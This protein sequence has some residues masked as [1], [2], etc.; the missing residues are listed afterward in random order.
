VVVESQAVRVELPRLSDTLAFGEEIGARLI[1]GDLVI[2]SGDL[3]AGKTALTKG[4]AVGMGITDLITSPTFVIA[5]VH[6]GDRA[7][8]VHVDGYRIGDALELDDLDLDTDLTRAAVVVEWGDGIAEQ[9][10]S[11]SLHIKLIRHLDDSRTAVLA[12]AGIRWTAAIAQL[13]SA[14]SATGPAPAEGAG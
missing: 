6:Y 4:I 14:V 5:R 9:L 10:A 13:P 11:E 2:L 8:L 12:A 1:A 3:G 7:P